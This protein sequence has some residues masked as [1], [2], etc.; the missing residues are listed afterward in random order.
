[1]KNK[2]FAPCILFIVCTL[3]S[4]AQDK[5]SK[6][7]HLAPVGSIKIHYYVSG[8]GPVCLVPSPGWGPSIAYQKN[9]LTPFEK[10]FTMVYYDT[11]LSG[12]STGPDDPG[13]YSSRDFMNDMDNLRK[14]LK[15]DKIWIMG[16]SAGGFQVLYYGIHHNSNL[17]GIIAL[18]PIAG[19]DSLYYAETLKIIMKREGQPYY[20][21]GSDIYLGKDTSRLTMSERM[22]YIFPFY[23]H[24]TEKIRD[25]Q[26]LGDSKMSNKASE[27]TNYCK[28]GQDYLFPD[29]H[30]IKVPVLIVVGDDD[31]ICDKVSQSDRIA[32][33]IAGSTE[34]VIKNA[35]HFSWIEQ[36]R[37]FFSDCEQ[38]LK[39]HGL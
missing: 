9:S 5:L 15:Q 13:K 17:H 23:F 32:K 2:Q 29:L 18:S 31:F 24:D 27:Y 33:N 35:G 28:F 39:A 11:R 37:Q 6:G 4:S 19:R 36:P 12:E 22:Q 8:R 25:F 10:H 16:H 21:K 20:E 38:W 1:M 3:V 34:I 30:K 14:Y 7:D 26:K